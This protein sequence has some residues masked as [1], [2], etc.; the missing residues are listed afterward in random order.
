MEKGLA[1]LR[2]ASK[3]I[4]RKFRSSILNA[5]K[6][7]IDKDRYAAAILKAIK[8]KPVKLKKG[9]YGAI[10]IIGFTPNWKIPV[11]TFPAKTSFT[12]E[13][14][15]D[16][17]VVTEQFDALVGFGDASA[18]ASDGEVDVSSFSGVAGYHMSRAQVGAF[19]TIP[20]G[21]R[22]LTLQARISSIASSVGADALGGASW[23]STGGIAEVTSLAD[24]SVT[25]RETSINY[26]VAPVIFWATDVFDGPHIINAEFP[27]SRDG[28]DIFVTAGLKCDV[29]AAAISGTG[30]IANGLVSKIKINI[31]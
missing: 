17:E 2:E 18:D 3:E 11:L 7:T 16:P 23:A 28:G 22:K 20:S 14:P 8:R 13:P 15:Y 31:S 6:Q 27:I 12:L 25:R 9:P 19:L 10:T 21:F 4:E 30:S 24:N 26:V 1:E 29:W 5:A